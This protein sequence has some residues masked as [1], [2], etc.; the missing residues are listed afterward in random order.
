MS[1]RRCRRHRRLKHVGTEQ[2]VALKILSVTGRSRHDGSL[3]RLL[4][5]AKVT[6]G[7]THPNTIRDFDE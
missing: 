5:E 2:E 4:R 6:A 1:D 3:D 7:L